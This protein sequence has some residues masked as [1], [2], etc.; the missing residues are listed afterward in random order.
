MFKNFAK[1]TETRQKAL[2]QI[3]QD[4]ELSAFLLQQEQN[5]YQKTNTSLPLNSLLMEPIQRGPRYKLLFQE[6]IKEERKG[7]TGGRRGDLE[8]VLYEVEKEMVNMNE[9]LRASEGKNRLA[10]ID[11]VKFSYLCCL[12][13]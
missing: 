4:T 1:A 11:Q 10:E 12:V 6:L 3:K 7:G 8:I 9:A 13:F 5:V 2:E